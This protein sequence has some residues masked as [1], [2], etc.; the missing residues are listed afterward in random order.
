M[1]RTI[2]IIDDEKPQRES[3]GGYFRKK[4]FEVCLAAS[5]KEGIEVVK[6]RTVDLVLTDYRMSGQTG[7]EVLTELKKINPEIVVILMTAYGTIETAVE[8]MKEGAFYYLQKPV[9]LDELDILIERSLMQKQLVSENRKLKEELAGRFKFESIIYQSKELEESLNIAGRVAKSSA[10]VLIRGESGTGKELFARA[11]HFAS[12]RKEQPFVVINCAALPETLLESEMFGYEKGAFTGAEQRR[13]GRFEEAMEGTIFIDEVGDIPLLTQVK[14]LRVLQ[15]GEFSR[16]GSNQVQKTK[17]RIITATN[18]NLEELIREKKFREDFYYRI[19]VVSI[20]IPPL[21]DRKADIPLLTD[22]FTRKFCPGGKK[23]VSNEAMDLLLKYSYPGNVRELENIVQ[24]ACVLS[25]D[26]VI[27]TYD[28]PV[29]V[30][31]SVN[32]KA[33]GAFTPHVGDLNEQT[34]ALEKEIIEMA[35]KETGGNQSKA[36]RLLNIS[37]R[38]LRYKLLKIQ[39]GISAE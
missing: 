35:L 23:Q 20:Q 26:E 3:L 36:A 37:E 32:E 13:I 12:D 14:L 11:I 4:G 30:K 1:N 38:N 25:R 2:L 9:N 5:G 15:S 7:Q 19:N 33:E 34:D 29:S 39:N 6:E 24:R 31:P 10:P 18:R 16:L 8:A 27:T 28:L 17:A 22:H 21:R